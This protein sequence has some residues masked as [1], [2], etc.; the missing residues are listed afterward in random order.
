MPPSR[1]RL[2]L[3]GDFDEVNGRSNSERIAAVH[4]ED[5]ALVESF[6]AYTGRVVFDLLADGRGQRVDGPRRGRWAGPG[7]RRER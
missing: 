6:D 2:Y 4:T 5:G 3:G 1:D 7:A